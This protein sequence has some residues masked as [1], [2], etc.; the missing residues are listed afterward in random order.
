MAAKGVLAGVPAARLLP[1]KGLDN[2]LIVAATEVTQDADIS[3]FVE[4]L[5]EVLS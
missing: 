4:N 1:G 2:H 3:A 5:R